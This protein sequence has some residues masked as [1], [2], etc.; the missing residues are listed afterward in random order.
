MITMIRPHVRNN[1]T[2]MVKKLKHIFTI[3]VLIDNCH[4]II[5]YWYSISTEWFIFIRL[6]FQNRCWMQLFPRF[7]QRCVQLSQNVYEHKLLFHHLIVVMKIFGD[8]YCISVIV[9]QCTNVL[10]NK[11]DK[12][13]Y[14]F[15]ITILICICK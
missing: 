15:I 5:F 11:N 13:I 8:F 12:P 1:W 3:I 7:F 6:N 2:C 14:S 10:I 4:N 9:R